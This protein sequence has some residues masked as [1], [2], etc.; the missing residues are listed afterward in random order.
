MTRQT[1]AQPLHLMATT[2]ALHLDSMLCFTR[3]V[4]A[5]G[6]QSYWKRCKMHSSCVNER[7]LL[8][9]LKTG[10]ELEV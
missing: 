6:R 5:L 9:P 7:G 3:T 4:C 2:R 8:P 10:T 1:T